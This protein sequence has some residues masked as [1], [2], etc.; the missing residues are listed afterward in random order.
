VTPVGRAIRLA[1]AAVALAGAAGLAC[2][3]VRPSEART[4]A[5]RP[6]T[7]GEWFVETGCTS[8][9]PVT[10]YGISS[11]AAVAP[12]L[13]TAVEDVPKRF[14][15]SLEDFLEAPTG[16]MAMVLA[17]RIRLSDQQRATA[18]EQLREAYRRFQ[19]AGAARP[20]SSH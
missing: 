4:A 9:H 17:G 2:V 11:V 20:V 5:G 13:S 16:T 10:V 8:C 15:R 6:L 18:V 7:G 14:G 1:A 12:D 19:N 3:P